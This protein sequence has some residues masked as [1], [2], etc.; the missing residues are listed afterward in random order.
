MFGWGK[1]KADISA[2]K[3]A[4]KACGCALVG[5]DPALVVECKKPEN[6]AMLKE[7]LKSLDW[8]YS[9]DEGDD[10]LNWYQFKKQTVGIA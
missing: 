9:P 5:W 3:A 6:A 4:I 2:E 10:A 1:K 8:I 7:Q